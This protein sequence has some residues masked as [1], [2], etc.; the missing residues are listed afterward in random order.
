MKQNYPV[1]YL[2]IWTI[3]LLNPNLT[4]LYLLCGLLT[5]GLSLGLAYQAGRL[6]PKIILFLLLTLTLIL[7]LMII[8]TLTFLLLNTT[9]III[10]AIYC[11]FLSL[12]ILI[13]LGQKEGRV[14][15]FIIE[16]GSRLLLIWLCLNFDGGPYLLA[17]YCALLALQEAL[18]SRKLNYSLPQ[19]P[20][21]LTALF[22]YLSLLIWQK[23]LPQDLDQ[24]DL[25]LLQGHHL[26][27]SATTLKERLAQSDQDLVILLQN[28]PASYDRIGHI[29]LAFQGRVYS[30]GNYDADSRKLLDLLGEGML[31][32]ADLDAYMDY[33]LKRH[34]SIFAY[35]FSLN[36]DQ[37]QATHNF[38]NHM[39]CQ[40]ELWLP[41]TPKQEGDFAGRMLSYPG[42]Q[43]HHIKQG[44]YKTYYL[45]GSNCVLFVKDLLRSLGY[46]LK[47]T[48]NIL[49]PGV[50][51]A[52]LEK[53]D[54]P[55][56]IQDRY[57][58]SAPLF[59]R[60]VLHK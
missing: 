12:Q 7:V 59:D 54:Q 58:V 36:P 55:N 26:I 17:I 46:P 41:Q 30:Y 11:L 22:P 57:L 43:F 39:L 8:P 18:P 56:F 38:L 3:L 14:Y 51:F 25:S 49:S 28:G 45:F 34:L 15:P 24:V 21:Y 27:Y 53:A 23:D 52:F 29:D 4:W 50:I 31:M 13:W 10:Q 32:T 35:S 47:T 60:F 9:I 19:L 33:L 37:I 2:L 5:L 42:S 44:S 6:K 1:L 20:I 40:S 16:I 48:T